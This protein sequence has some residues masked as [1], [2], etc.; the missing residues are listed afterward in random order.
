[1]GTKRKLFFCGALMALSA[2]TYTEKLS[3][4]RPWKIIDGYL[5]TAGGKTQYLIDGKPVR[6][7][8]ASKDLSNFI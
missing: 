4:A 6:V 7:L 8:E 5:Y 2:V 1:M 3:L